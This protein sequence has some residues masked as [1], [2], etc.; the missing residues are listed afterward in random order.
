LDKYVTKIADP[1]QGIEVVP[2]IR[3][4][5][6]QLKVDHGFIYAADL[7]GSVFLS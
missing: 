7:I 6:S 5:C 1:I 2:V 4:I 3:P